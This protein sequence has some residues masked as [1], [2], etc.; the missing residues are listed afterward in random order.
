MTGAGRGED[1]D[2]YVLDNGG[3]FAVDTGDMHGAQTTSAMLTELRSYFPS[4]DAYMKAWS[5]EVVKQPHVLRME[6]ARQLLERLK[7]ER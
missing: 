4:H 1:M 2:G 3:H 7:R 6:T 5:D